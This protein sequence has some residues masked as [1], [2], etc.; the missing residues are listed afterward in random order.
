MTEQSNILTQD[1]VS[2]LLNN[3]APDNSGFSIHDLA[4]S[5]S[6]FANLVKIDFEDKLSQ[7]VVVRRYNTAHSGYEDKAIREYKALELLQQ[8]DVPAPKPLFLD[9][10]GQVLGLTGIVTAFVEGKQIEPPTQVEDWGQ[11]AT[12]NAKMLA[13][14]HS[15]SYGEDIK[16]YLMDDEVEG[17]WFLK[18]DTMPNYLINDHDGKMVWELLT[19]LLPKRHSV[20]LVFSH[21]DYW[22]GNIMWHEGEVSAV[23]DWE[24]AAYGDPAYDV[25]Y[26]RMEYVLEGLPEASDEFLRVYEAE[27]GRS[28]V[29]L[30]LWE[31]A[32]SVR[33]MTDP[34]GWFTRPFM[35]ERFRQFIADAKQ[36][37]IK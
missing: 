22:S 12:K 21:T 37:A 32:C 8:H 4:G 9:T 29:N 24:E 1:I 7:Q 2:K 30:G 16:P 27:T 26:A 17:A 14:I 31:L 33:P 28:L 36:R 25:A 11:S 5:Y 23:V 19:D 35:Q 10:E 3:I 13:K 20:D 15:V 18:Y 6:N 34:D